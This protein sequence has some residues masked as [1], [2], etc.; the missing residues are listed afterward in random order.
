MLTLEII[1][2]DI[3]SLISILQKHM[4]SK[5]V[6]CV[7]EPDKYSPQDTF[8]V[9][10]W[11][12]ILFDQSVLSNMTGYIY[13][14]GESHGWSFLDNCRPILAQ[15]VRNL[16]NKVRQANRTNMYKQELL[17]KTIYLD[18]FDLYG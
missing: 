12:S 5:I 2:E 13:S 10:I 15:W 6:S 14:R 18:K 16:A 8:S 17:E 4:D 1:K 9:T 11:Y 7:V 3:E